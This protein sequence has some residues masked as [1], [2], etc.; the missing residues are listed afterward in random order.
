MSDNVIE[1]DF[2]A[3]RDDNEDF[4]SSL[5]KTITPVLETTAG[6][7][8]YSPDGAYRLAQKFS[9][10]AK[11]MFEYKVN[12]NVTI[13]P[14]GP[15]DPMAFAQHVAKLVGDQVAQHCANEFAR[16]VSDIAYPLDR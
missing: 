4:V 6:Q 15:P 10:T 11:R 1:I 5:A 2:G 9:E 13:P 12:V 8:G 16:V 7:R 3:K 14:N